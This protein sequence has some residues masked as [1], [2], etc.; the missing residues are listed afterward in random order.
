MSARL[1]RRLSKL[2]ADPRHP[3]SPGA[4]QPPRRHTLLAA[5]FL[6]ALELPEELRAFGAN[7][8]LEMEPLVLA[9]NRE[10]QSLDATELRVY[11][12]GEAQDW[13]PLAWRLRDDLARWRQA[14]TRVRLMA[15]A[16][17][18]EALSASQ[19][20]ELAALTAYT[21][22]ELYR[23]PDLNPAAAANLPL[24]LELG[25]P[26]QRVRWA[27][28]ESTA[29]IPGPVWGGG[30]AGGPFIRTTETQPLSP[31]PESWRR[32]KLEELRPVTAGLIA[33]TITNELNG[34]STTFGERAWT[35]LEKQ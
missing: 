26:D 24:I 13:E 32:L 18:L 7:S 19:R 22:A 30:E 9:L 8:Q 6:A 28:R 3:T 35:L 2:P 15:P 34:P 4:S 5:D 21:G 17:T 12:G 16:A 29:L 25:G 31:L 1:R 23:I 10:G 27:A 20:D 14:G 11:L 33:L